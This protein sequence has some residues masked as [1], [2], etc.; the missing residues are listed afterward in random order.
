MAAP[1][2]SILCLS[3]VVTSPS[4]VAQD[5]GLPYWHHLLFLYGN[6]LLAA[7]AVAVSTIISGA[8]AVSRF[9]AK[10]FVPVQ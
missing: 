9:A 2:L 10:A 3:T 4:C 7:I 5:T 8:K 1:P 6:R